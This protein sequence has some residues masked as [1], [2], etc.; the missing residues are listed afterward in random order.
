MGAG[1]FRCHR[2]RDPHFTISRETDHSHLSLARR[3]RGMEDEA[4]LDRGASF[5]KHVCDEEE[6]EA[7][8][9]Q[10]TEVRACHGRSSQ[11]VPNIVP[12]KLLIARWDEGEG[13]EGGHHTI[14]IGVHV[15][16]SYRRRRRH[17]RKTGH[18]EKKEK[19][20]IS[21]NYSDKSDVENAD[22]SSSSILK[23]L[24][25]CTHVHQA[26]SFLE[27]PA[28]AF[29]QAQHGGCLGAP[30][31]LIFSAC[32]QGSSALR[33][34]HVDVH[35]FTRVNIHLFSDCESNHS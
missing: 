31:P 22:E 34:S 21:E 3:K 4:V 13:K 18:R 11:E 8:S 6:V 30:S 2:D 20:R 1:D 26:S 14:Y 33:W 27:S 9:T 29:Q 12:L 10:A 7:D 25:V 35:T 28:E 24:S 5:L 17:K 23:P 15:P 16:K 32:L 19:E